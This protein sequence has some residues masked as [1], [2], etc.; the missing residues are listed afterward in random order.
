MEKI[1]VISSLA[2]LN[3]GS[4]KGGSQISYK[5]IYFCSTVALGRAMCP[6][7]YTVGEER[8]TKGSGTPSPI[9]GMEELGTRMGL[10]EIGKFQDK[11]HKCSHDLKGREIISRIEEISAYLCHGFQNY[12]GCSDFFRFFSW[13]SA[14]S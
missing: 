7:V 13:T 12:L 10:S 11:E 8:A 3:Q 14:E 2:P 6:Y 1:K 9:P 5:T 4:D